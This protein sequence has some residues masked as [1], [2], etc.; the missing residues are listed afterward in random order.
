[1]SRKTSIPGPVKNR[2]A[3]P[4]IEESTKC[5]AGRMGA[6]TGIII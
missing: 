2:P 4:G 1:V 3:R 5:D 6:G